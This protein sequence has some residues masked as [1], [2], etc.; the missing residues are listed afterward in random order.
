MTVTLSK[1]AETYVAEV[2]KTW[3]TGQPDEVVSSLILK[4]RADDAYD[5]EHP[6]LTESQLVQELL[7]GVRAPHRPYEPG[8][9][10]RLAER[11][12]AERE[13]A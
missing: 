5:R 4:Q 8:E 9:F 11:L 2:M 3:N 1:E 12:V 10:R 13:G 7:E 6:P